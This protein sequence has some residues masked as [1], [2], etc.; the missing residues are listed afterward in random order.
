MINS[1]AIV[2]LVSSLKHLTDN[3]IV[4]RIEEGGNKGLVVSHGNILAQL[5][6]EDEQT[7]TSISNKIGRCKSTLT[8]LV[9][10]LEKA[11]FIIRKVDSDDTR[12]KKLCLT[13]KGKE[14]KE[15]FWS[16]SSDLNQSLWQGFN[17]KE[18]QELLSY[19]DRMNKNL[20]NIAQAR[21][22]VVDNK[23]IGN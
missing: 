6:K 17:E 4:Q 14:F 20:E 12:I 16:I 7:M 9:D 13:D 11:G 19:L 18:Q 5:Y 2:K 21:S 22:Q 10:K 1:T 8:V 15:V 23:A 3:Y